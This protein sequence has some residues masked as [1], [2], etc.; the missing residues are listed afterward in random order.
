MKGGI[1][2]DTL[3]SHSDEVETGFDEVETGFDDLV[4]LFDEAETVFANLGSHSDEVETGSDDLGPHFDEVEVVLRLTASC[5][6]AGKLLSD[7]FSAYYLSAMKK[8]WSLL[9]LTLISAHSFAQ[10]YWQQK[11][12]TRIDVTLD[13][14]SHMLRGHESFVY[15]NNSPDTLRYLY[16][17]LWPNAYSHDHTQFAEQQYRNGS[18]SFYYAKESDRG[19]IDSLSFTVD[20]K[21]TDYHIT[22]ATPD[23]ARIDLPKPLLPGGRINVSTPFRV[24]MPKVFS[25]MGHTGQAYFASQWFPKPAVYDR[26]GWHPI[27]YLDLGEFYSEIGSYEVSITVPSNYVVMATGNLQDEQEIKWLDSLA[28]LPLPPDSLR[29]KTIASS[30]TLKTLHYKE[31]NV[32]DFAWF[33]DKRWV[34][35]KKEL[36]D[37]GVTAWSAFLPGSIKQWDKANDHLANAVKY[38]GKWV[39]AYPYKTIKAV[40]GDMKAGGGMEYPTVT[41]IDRGMADQTTIIH[42]AGHN[43]FYGILATNERDHAWMDE[44]INTFYEEKSG[45]AIDKEDTAKRRGVGKPGGVNVD[46]SMPT[47]IHQLAASGKDEPINQTSN[48]FKEINYGM[49]VYYKTAMLLRWLEDYMGEEEFEAAMHEY[50]NTWKHKHPYPEDLRV[51]FAKH[52]DKPL[53]WFFDSALNTDR[54]VDFALKGVST[55]GGKTAITVRNRTSQ[56]FPVGIKAYENDSLVATVYSL[57]FNG[58]TTLDLP[59]GTSWNRLKISGKVFDARSTNNEYRKS[60]LFHRGGIRP[61]LLTG[62]T[63]GRNKKIYFLPAVDYNMYDGFAGGLLIHNLGWPETRFKYILAPMYAFGSKEFVGAGSLSYSFYPR[64]TFKEVTVQADIKSFNF[65]LDKTNRDEELFARYL[66]IAPSLQFTFRQSDK[67]STVNR[68]LLIKGYSINEESF[69]YDNEY[70]DSLFRASTVTG[71]HTYALIRYTHRNSRPFNP[72]SYSLEAQGG[73][74]FAKLSLEGALRIDY[75]K[76]GKYF[77]IRAY[78]GKFFPLDENADLSR[79]YLNTTHTGPNDYLYDEPYIGRSEREGFGA[80]QFAMKEGGFKIATPLLSAPIGRSD[81]WLAALNLKTDLPLGRLPLR[82]FLDVA[83]FADAAKLN[84]S[85]NKLLYEAGLE[86]Y[87]FDMIN[88]YLPFMLSKDYNDY[89]KTVV[90]KDR[91]LNSIS[92]SIQL[93]RIN[94]LK[95]PSGIFK[96]IGY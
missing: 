72:F 12:D 47:I 79:Y 20:E 17:H 73:E 45:E 78:G 35:R 94:W 74:G 27:P 77:H 96:L 5:T 37:Y 58:T 68:T 69:E 71:N 28:A 64:R 60:G 39:G 15:T 32:H 30:E 2:F 81:N 88:I 44:G 1:D 51:I 91:L 95:A 89:M 56:A 84:P 29:K 92:F 26:K 33:A 21:E 53:D 14:K 16:I 25:R 41:V 52:T 59:A 63:T 85:G 19:F 23:I 9:T 24:K 62:T 65:D 13:D 55:D 76:K 48:N 87:F 36:K 38:Y 10:S 46:V 80:H 75:H 49:D 82:L 86:L 4:S 83:T 61:A 11:A 54:V 70:P 8:T 22:D 31:D 66:K 34:V 6:L 57:P 90:G 18:K 7:C 50:Y 3:A 93:N 67:L 43:W 42:E 40:E